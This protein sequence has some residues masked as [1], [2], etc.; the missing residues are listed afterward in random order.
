MLLE[1]LSSKLILQVCHE[2]NQKIALAPAAVFSTSVEVRKSPHGSLK[3]L[4]EKPAHL[5]VQFNIFIIP[6]TLN[7]AAKCKVP[8][9]LC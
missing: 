6:C 7:P 5:L 4:V 2:R 8:R 3:S 1:R 9:E